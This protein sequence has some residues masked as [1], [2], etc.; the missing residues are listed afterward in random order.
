MDRRQRPTPHP[1]V[2]ATVV[3][4]QAVIVMADSGQVTV[5]NEVGTRIWQLSDGMRS[6]EEII[7]TIV[8]EYEVTPEVAW[9]DAEVFLGRLIEV[10][11][12]QMNDPQT[13]DED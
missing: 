5:L 9:Q 10:Q 3:D 2:A 1:Q 13:A 12:I 8:D 6:L 7:A 11:A 4:G